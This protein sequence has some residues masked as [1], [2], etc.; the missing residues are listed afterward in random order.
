MRA[1]RGDGGSLNTTK[2]PATHWA[3]GVRILKQTYPMEPQ[4]FLGRLSQVNMP[5]Y[6][7]PMHPAATCI[8]EGL[9]EQRGCKGLPPSTPTQERRKWAAETFCWGPT[10]SPMPIMWIS[11]CPC[12]HDWPL[13]KHGMQYISKHKDME[14]NGGCDARAGP[15]HCM[16]HH[17]H[18]H[19][20]RSFIGCPC[21]CKSNE[22]SRKGKAKQKAEGE[23][24]K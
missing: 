11:P 22:W 18:A 10:M 7:A 5:G 23:A 24:S 9:A 1:K 3:P 8:A 12:H 2:Q 16:A 21:E 6:S 14:G 15:I 4:C 20:R 17:T 19:H 13:K